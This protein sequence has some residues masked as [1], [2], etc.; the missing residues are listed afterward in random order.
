MTARET[1]LQEHAMDSYIEYRR[2][3]AS[4]SRRRRRGKNGGGVVGQSTWG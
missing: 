1:D 4:P 2:N 3:F